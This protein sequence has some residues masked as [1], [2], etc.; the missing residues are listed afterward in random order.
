MIRS[1]LRSRRAVDRLQPR[2]PDVPYKRRSQPGKVFSLLPIP[3]QFGMLISAIA[4]E[5][6]TQVARCGGKGW[7]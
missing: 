2:R 6:P 1:E 7:A 5:H 3:L 4:A